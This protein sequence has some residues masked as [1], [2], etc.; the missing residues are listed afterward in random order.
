MVFVKKNVDVGFFLPTSIDKG[1]NFKCE[2]CRLYFWDNKEMVA[3]WNRQSLSHWPTPQG[4][5]MKKQRPARRRDKDTK[6]TAKVHT[7]RWTGFF[8]HIRMT[9]FW[10][11]HLRGVG[12]I[13][14]VAGTV[15]F[16]TFSPHICGHFRLGFWSRLPPGGEGCDRLVL[17]KKID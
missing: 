15:F 17:Q 3:S 12:K 2:M 5:K 9:G 8:F 4:A 14:I 10:P 7:E 11:G 13:T 1:K 16:P 6:Q